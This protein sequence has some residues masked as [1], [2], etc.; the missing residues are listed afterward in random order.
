MDN[1][2]F[3][4][5][6]VNVLDE[7]VVNYWKNLKQE[8]GDTLHMGD[9]VVCE[10]AGILVVG[11]VLWVHGKSAC[12]RVTEPV[13]LEIGDYRKYRMLHHGHFAVPVEETI[14]VTR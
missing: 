14:A 7:T 13:R 4:T 11:D 12:V 3:T 6:A 8:Y 2:Y 10:I 5:F 9:T 1:T